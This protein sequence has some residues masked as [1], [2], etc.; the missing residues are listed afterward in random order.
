M[1]SSTP[2]IIALVDDD[3]I[4]QLTASKTILATQ[5]TDRILQFHN[6]EE[7]LNYILENLS[8]PDVLPDYI[9]LDINM[10]FVD[11]W[12]FLEDYEMLKPKLP[13]AI[14]IYMISSS[15]D[16]RDMKRARDNAN[17][18]DY[19]IKPVSVEKFRQLLQRV[20]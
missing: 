4:F 5:V 20:A 8:H 9:F 11:G 16:P 3:K 19:V 12:M 13:K 2:P 1:T 15:I 10:P 17:I 18:K 6:G 14:S 7:A